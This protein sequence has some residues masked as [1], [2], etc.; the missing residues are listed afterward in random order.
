[1][2]YY[3]IQNGQDVASAFSD[4]VNPTKHSVREQ[5]WQR[6]CI[7]NFE[8]SHRRTLAAQLRRQ[9]PE[10]PLGFE[11][12]TAEHDTGHKEPEESA[13]ELCL[14]IPEHA[15]AA[16]RRMAGDH[17]A[18][19]SLPGQSSRSTLTTTLHHACADN[20]SVCDGVGRID[21]PAEATIAVAIAK[22]T[23][24]ES[25]AAASKKEVSRR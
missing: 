23:T 3:Q 17:C 25:L 21:P 4:V 13:A 1:M 6:F 9:K 12:L 8:Q 24:P 16:V 20:Q 11:S 7:K 19:R 2:A 10:C 5:D 15:L 18:V 22:W 14:Q